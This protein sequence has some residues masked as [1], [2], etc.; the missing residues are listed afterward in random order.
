MSYLTREENRKKY[1][2]PDY[3][4]GLEKRKKEL[5]SRLEFLR[6]TLPKTKDESDWT[7]VVSEINSVSVDIATVKSRIENYGNG[8][9][10]PEIHSY[11]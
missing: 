1:N 2:R 3:L 6:D 5:E 4:G 9:F 7:K 8:K 10:V 11:K